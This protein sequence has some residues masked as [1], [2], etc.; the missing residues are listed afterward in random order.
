MGLPETCWVGRTRL[1]TKTSPFCNY[2]MEN[3]WGYEKVGKG[4]RALLE[5]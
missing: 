3:F 2:K 4:L 5:A 1:G